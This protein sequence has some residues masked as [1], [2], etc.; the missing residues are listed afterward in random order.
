MLFDSNPC[1]E[2]ILQLLIL[3]PQK[4][5]RKRTEFQIILAI[6]KPTE[7]ILNSVALSEYAN[8]L[9]LII[10]KEQPPRV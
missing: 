9:R 6:H 4:T 2:S 10:Y 5:S 3:P 8:D 7:K 1:S